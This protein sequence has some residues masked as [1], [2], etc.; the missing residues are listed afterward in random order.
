MMNN[1]HIKVSFNSVSEAMLKQLS[2]NMRFLKNME[3]SYK[4]KICF[5]N[6]VDLKHSQDFCSMQ[7]LLLS[8]I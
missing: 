2:N 7:F 5:Y 3:L 1:A 4:K 6:L 8:K